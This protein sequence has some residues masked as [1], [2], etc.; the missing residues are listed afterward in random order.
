MHA[1]SGIVTI[2]KLGL[3][4]TRTYWVLKAGIEQDISDYPFLMYYCTSGSLLSHYKFTVIHCS[5]VT[6][7]RPIANG[8]NTDFNYVVCSVLGC[9]TV[10]MCQGYLD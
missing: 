7:G 10:T 4:Y 9:S 3:F 6:H 8:Y 5:V 2:L 1:Q